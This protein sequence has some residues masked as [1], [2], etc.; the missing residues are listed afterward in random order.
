MKMICLRKR[1]NIAGGVVK[2]EI[3]TYKNVQA[4]LWHWSQKHYYFNMYL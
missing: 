4:L 1:P 3:F 2:K